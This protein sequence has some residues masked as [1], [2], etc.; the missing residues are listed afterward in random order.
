MPP[1]TS[2]AFLH[3]SPNGP[4]MTA[5]AEQR[6]GGTGLHLRETLGPLAHHGIPDLNGSLIGIRGGEA[7][8]NAQKRHC[9]AGNRKVNK[10]TG[11]QRAC[12][13]RCRDYERK[14]AIGDI[15]VRHNSE[16]VQAG[17]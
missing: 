5:G 14:N 17:G 11:F 4:S 8:R 3:P 7:Q 15:L 2:R 16:V 9:V 6:R 1:P 13:A 10:L 12:E